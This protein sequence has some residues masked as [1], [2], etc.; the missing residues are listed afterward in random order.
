[1]TG[2]A[3]SITL[4]LARALLV[5][6][7]ALKPA[8]R[9]GELQIYRALRTANEPCSRNGHVRRKTCG[10]EEAWP[11]KGEKEASL[12]QAVIG[13]FL[14]FSGTSSCSGAVATT[15]DQICAVSAEDLL[16]IEVHRYL[17]PLLISASNFLNSATSR[18]VLDWFFSYL[19]CA[20]SCCT[21]QHQQALHPGALQDAKFELLSRLSLVCMRFITSALRFSPANHTRH[22]SLVQSF[23]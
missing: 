17:I 12:G 23:R 16:F 22:S 9:R 7:P 6:E 13:H 2:Q 8:L 1:M 11:F 21:Y 14:L 20:S 19:A 15:T 4:A 10:E 18:L 5:H 3:E